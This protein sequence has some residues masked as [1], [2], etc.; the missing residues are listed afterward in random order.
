MVQLIRSGLEGLRER[1]AG[2]VVSPKD[3]GYESMR[4]IWNGA[5][6]RHP[7][8]IVRCGGPD[9]AEAAV[10]YARQ[11][12]LEISVRGGGHG[13][14]G[15]AVTDGGVMLDLS[16]LRQIEVD[17]ASRWASCGGGATW[18]DLD[19]ATHVYGLATPGGTI[20]HTGVG[21]LTL[22]GGFGWLSHDHGLTVDN[23][24]SA[25]VV[26][27]DGRQVHASA[28]EHPDLFWAL[29]GGGG[30]FGVVTSFAFRLH[31]VGP[32]V[33]VGVLFWEAE[34]GPEAIETIDQAVRSLPEH[35]GVLIAFGMSAPP[36]P[37]VPEEHRLRQGHA[38]IVAGFGSPRHHA[39]VLEPITRALPPL[40]S[41][42]APMSYPQLQSLLDDTVPWGTPAYEKALDLPSLGTDAIATLCEQA[43][44]KGSPMSFIPAFRLDGAFSAI[45]DAATAFGGSREPHYTLSVMALTRTADALEQERTWA[46]DAWSA[47]LPY[48][49]GTG[50][51]VNFLT[52]QDE[53]RVR[54]S[55]GE[56][57]YARLAAIKA[58]YDPDNV[59][60]LNQNIR[61]ATG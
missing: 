11:E 36:A 61:P 22:G 44:L 20:S 49:R 13:F 60:R 40:F 35:V 14:G 28:R 54:A 3:D 8:V 29:R 32:E 17:A 52:D 38:L 9:D 15:L 10:A 27:A 4:R 23:L 39:S 57:K 34:R 47:L 59:F 25:D 43:A 18:A 33:Q 46:R 53:D 41:F 16:A 42:A 6:D 7:G 21:G 58:E 26:L 12:D 51:Y 30:N 1:C 37:F 5:V 48:S 56:E 31:P 55:Y 19:A 2:R 24:E 45:P 50:A